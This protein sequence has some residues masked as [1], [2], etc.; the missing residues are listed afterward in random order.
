MY[1]QV[2]PYM[3]WINEDTRLQNLIHGLIRRQT[4]QILQ[5]PFANAFNLDG[6]VTG[7]HTD[8]DTTKP[9]F[10]HTRIKYAGIVYIYKLVVRI[11]HE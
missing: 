5:D 10:L 1:F 11:L 8:D 9:G 3:R 2:M 7:L 4:Q 6:T